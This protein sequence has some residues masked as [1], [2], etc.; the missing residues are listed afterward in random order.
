MSSRLMYVSLLV[1]MGLGVMTPHQV[2]AQRDAAAKIRGDFRS[3]WDPSY[4]RWGS[5]SVTRRS[6]R[7]QIVYRSYPSVP[8][9]GAIAV[10]PPRTVAPQ[11]ATP[12]PA[13]VAPND[14]AAAPQT[15]ARRFSYDPSPP[16][17]SAPA[18]TTPSYTYY[19]APRSRT[20]AERR[21]EAWQYPKSEARHWRP[22]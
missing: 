12:A 11:V 5:S 4:P 22:F 8:A 10:A 21:L 13:A 3:F 16:M 7:P 6:A 20:R 17:V 18:R 9:P 1:L 19:E 15:Q 14:L 2:W